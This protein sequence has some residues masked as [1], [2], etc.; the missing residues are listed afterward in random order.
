MLDSMTEEEVDVYK[1]EN[2]DFVPLFEIDVL[3]ILDQ[4]AKLSESTAVSTLDAESLPSPSLKALVELNQASTNLKRDL[5]L[6]QRA[7]A[8]ELNLGTQGALHVV[9]I[10]KHLPNSFRTQLKSYCSHT[11]MFLHGHT[12]TCHG[13]THSFITTK[14]QYPLAVSSSMLLGH[15]DIG[16]PGVKW[17]RP[18]KPFIYMP[19]FGMY[20]C[21]GVLL[22]IV[23]VCPFILG[24]L[25]IFL[26]FILSSSFSFCNRSFFFFYF[27]L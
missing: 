13:S 12:L 2:P 15:S 23:S 4:R 17:A 10:A 21:V 6:T 25:S 27:F 3:D 16:R 1:E 14:L 5:T 26:L 18:T 22:R 7:Q 24:V 8:T 9:L 19:F 20:G 11:R